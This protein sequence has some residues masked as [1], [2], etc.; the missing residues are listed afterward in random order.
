MKIYFPLHQMG[1]KR[2]CYVCGKTLGR[3]T[4]FKGGLAYFP[5]WIVKLDMIGSDVENFGCPYCHCIDRERHLFM[6]FDKLK[7]WDSIKGS[8]ILHFAPEP[9]L[10]KRIEGHAP[11]NYVRGDLF[12]ANPTIRK[13]DATAIDFPDACF[14]IVLANHVLEHIPD[15]TRAIREVYR[16]LRPG[17]FAILQTPFSKRLQK[18]FEDQGINTE[19]L[20]L[21]F[22][23]QRDHVRVFSEHEFLQSLQEAGFA[24]AFA[25]HADFF[26]D[27]ESYYYGVN[28]REDF[29]RVLK[30]NQ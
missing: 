5:E 30:P 28:K 15:Y 3:F 16:V 25:K 17:G 1:N 9:N 6:Y 24:L 7:V 18:N 22:Y 4:K 2:K 11:A 8:H 13:I 19:D 26:T 10:S 12:P 21:Y 27:E 29:I 14:D 23:A 20:R